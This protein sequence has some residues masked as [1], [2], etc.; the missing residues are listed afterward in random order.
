MYAKNVAALVALLA[1]HG[2]L[3]LNFADDIIAA[4]VVT[5]GGEIRHAATRQRLGMSNPT[6]YVAEPAK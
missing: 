4:V 6:S 3:N 5:A 2:E 1:P